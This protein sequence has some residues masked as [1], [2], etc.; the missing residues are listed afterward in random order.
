MKKKIRFYQSINTK[1]VFV[2]VLLLVFALQL[3]G[4]NFI[5]Q[6]ERQLVANFQEDRQ[7][8]MNFLKSTVLPYL[9]ARESGSESEIDPEQEIG[10]L[11]TEFSGSG[12][13][14]LQVVDSE[15]I[16]LGTSDTTQQNI[17]GQLSDDVDL[18]QAQITES[19]IPRQVI[20]TVTQNR[21]WKIVEPVFS[22]GEESQFLGAI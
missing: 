4:A 10:A 8:Q 12:I 7:V 21:R 22:N 19:S 9:E 16:V 20:D 6:I 17:V 13:T 3:I 18:R 14:D 1:I 2:I 15:L 11:L 5:T